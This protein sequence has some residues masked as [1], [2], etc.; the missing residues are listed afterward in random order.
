D[1]AV[2]LLRVEMAE[3]RQARSPGDFIRHLQCG[4]RVELPEPES[5]A[6][7][8][9][10]EKHRREAVIRIGRAACLAPAEFCVPNLLPAGPERVAV[11]E[12]AAFSKF[13]ARNELFNRLALIGKGEARADIRD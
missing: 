12:L 5:L 3:S 8:K 2:N 1:G 6:G 11:G 4:Q 7:I 13:R 9:G 10:L